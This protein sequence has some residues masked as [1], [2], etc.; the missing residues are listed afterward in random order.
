M[1]NI[2][3]E[4]EQKVL[5]KIVPDKNA[6]LKL[7]T[8]IEELKTVVLKHTKKI[9]FPIEI[10]LVGSTA[11]DTYLRDSL[12]IDLFVCFPTTTSREKLEKTGLSIGRKVLTKREECFA[13]HPYLRGEFKGY[14]TEIVPCYK[15]ESA[16][17]K[18]SAVDRTPLHTTYVTEH[19]AEE[20]KNEVRLLKQFLKGIGCYGAEAEVEGFSGYLCEILILKYNSFQ[21]LLV[22]AQHWRYGEQLFLHNEIVPYFD[23]PLIFIDPID[24]E[25]NVASALSKE[26]SDLFM[27]ACKAYLKRPQI[28]FFFPNKIKPWSLD[29]IKKEIEGKEFIGI[30]I[31]KP[32]IIAEN[33]YPQVRKAVRSIID[34][35]TQYDFTI[36]DSF[37]HITNDSIYIVLHPEKSKISETMFHTGP[38]VDLKKN[39]DDFIEKW[40]SNQ[41]TIKKPFEKDNRLYVEIKREYVKIKELLEKQIKALSLGKHI[42]PIVQEDFTILDRND[43]LK[44]TFCM[45]WTEYLDKRMSWE[46]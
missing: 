10:E 38:P 14:K 17:Q 39:A 43:L 3:K 5:E 21:N 16:S 41:Q 23:T 15:I 34:L 13:E 45:L 46:R 6:R 40:T 25:R 29:K 12:D 42:D 24:G 26:K 27:N 36:I 35:C 37:F 2:S 31:K 22:C 20:Q 18:L 44:E 32:E 28:T 4:V 19:L 33:L 1:N 8:T 9:N 11:K 30:K 7:E